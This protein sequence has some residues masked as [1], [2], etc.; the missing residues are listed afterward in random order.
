MN[1]TQTMKVNSKSQ[2]NKKEI[3][4]SPAR[5]ALNKF[6]KHK[7]A[8][9]G[10]VILVL[11]IILGVFASSIAPYNPYK[12]DLSNVF[13]QPSAENLLGTDNL[14]RDVL[15]RLIYATRVSLIVAFSSVVGYIIIGLFLGLVSGYY[16]K[17]IDSIIGRLTDSVLS[18]PPMVIVMVVV[19]IIGPGLANLAIAIMLF[20]WPHACRVVRGEVLYLRE[21]TFV[22]AGQSI[23][24]KTPIILFRHI[25]PNVIP[26]LTVASTFGLAEVILL[27]AGLSFLGAGVRQPMASWG[28]MLMAA[29][30][31]TVL[32]TMPWLWLPPGIMIII[33]VLSINFVGDGLRDALDPK[34]K[35]A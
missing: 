5:V 16:G 24:S 4:E 17:I 10:V 21:Q 30:S 25:L 32:R 6:K 8:M 11:F 15:S 34:T 33:V 2:S 35:E 9:T 20:K 27:E 19:T 7:L 22:K 12:V 31:L 13:A 1:S 23:G 28:N 3:I 29:Q 26:S 14:G 18:F